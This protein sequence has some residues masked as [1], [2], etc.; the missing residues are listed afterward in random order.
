MSTIKP[1]SELIT[2]MSPEAGA[3]SHRL[4]LKD[5]ADML[6]SMLGHLV[7]LPHRQMAELLDVPLEDLIDVEYQGDMTVNEIRR[8]I[9]ELD[10]DVEVRF[11]IGDRRF[12][13]TSKASGARETTVTT[14]A[15]ARERA[16]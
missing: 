10:A 4:Y 5:R 16:A 15:D 2:K 8:L 6:K 7:D 13:V 11:R 1:L 9:E 14:S 12:C 3:E